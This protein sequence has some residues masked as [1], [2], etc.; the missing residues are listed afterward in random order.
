MRPGPLA[1]ALALLLVAPRVAAGAPDVVGVLAVAEPPGPSGELSAATAELRAALAASMPGVL[2]AAELRERI[3]GK[4][5][6]SSLVELQRAHAAA[7]AAYGAGEFEASIKTLRAVVEAL[8]A[9]APSADVFAEWTATMLRLARTEQELG[10]RAEAQALLEKLLRAAPDARPDAR[11]YPP[12]FLALVED[13]RKR[14]R[15]LGVRH[16]TVESEPGVRVF[17]EGREVGTSP[18]ST[19]LPPGRYR[20]A[21]ERGGVRAAS[22]V[23]DLSEEDR[24]LQLDL[25]VVE[26]LR[27]DGGP[28]LALAVPDRAL[29]VVTAA[30]RLGLDRA[31]TTSLLREGEVVF[32]VA[33]LHDLRLGRAEREGRIRLEGGAAPAGGIAALAAFLALG[34]ASALVWTP[35]GRPTLALHAAPPPEPALALPADRHAARARAY[36]WG[37]IGTSLGM[38][39][40]GVLTSK[41][42]LDT[43]V[44][45]SRAN[46]LLDGTGKVKLGHSTAEYNGL[47]AEGDRA[48][49]I[50]IGTGI[51]TAVGIAATIVLSIASDREARQVGT[52][53]F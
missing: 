43:Q 52:F 14:L 30:T 12:S 7:V 38:I 48:R 9:L 15:S 11:R 41:Y 4:P 28:G 46:A 35:S 44:W 10:R 39:V 8:E 33:T 1:A 45:Y 26:A 2:G 36:R 27:P 31:V 32:L 18:V 40:A 29:R 51:G 20:V 34:R 49:T 3:T 21:G 37:A 13:A 25:S 42:V 5:P 53:Q 47:I 16:L 22:T 23:A 24:T 19:A 17:V 50:A 6:P